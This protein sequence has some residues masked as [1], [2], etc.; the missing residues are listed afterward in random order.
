MRCSLN[1]HADI[2]NP[3][4]F[5]LNLPNITLLAVSSVDIEST[6]LALRISSHDIIFGA[7]KFLTSEEWVSTDPKIEVVPIPRINF[8]G[9]SKFM[10]EELVHY[11]DTEFCLVIQADGF[12]LN[13][14]RWSPKFL[15]YDYVGAPWPIDLRLQPGNVPIDISANSVGNGG[16]SLRS[17][18]LLHTTSKIDF[19]EL[20]F[21][22]KS[23]DLIICHYLYEQML[24]AGIKFPNPDLAAQFSI[25]SPTAVYG[26]NPKTSFGFHGKSLR[27]LIFKGIQ[28][29]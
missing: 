3:E 5:M 25:E 24:A 27:D 4:S 1:N 6:D 23:E 17:K 28:A 26:Q 20:F 15:E 19:D 16:F 21:P 10:L 14:S 18:K 13:A 12:V 9:Y 22:S 7:I 2:Y 29:E 8:E 11:V